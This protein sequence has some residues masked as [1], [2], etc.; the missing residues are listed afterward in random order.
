MPELHILPTTDEAVQAMA[1]FVVDLARER[2]AAQGR[3]T[4]A[5]SGGSTPRLLY[6][7]LA[8]Q[9]HGPELEWDRWHVFWRDERCVPVG[10]E[11]SNYRMAKNALLDHVNIPERQVHRMRGEDVPR[12]AATDY[13]A[14][15][16][17]V[18]Q[19]ESPSFD[20]VL[21]GMGD[22]GHTASLFPGTQ[23]LGE[24]DRLV[25]DNWAPSL[26]VHR[27]TFTLPL[28]NAAKAVAFLEIDET[29]AEML[30]PVLEPAP[31][32]A[33]SP[34]GFVHPSPGVV[35]WFLTTAAAVRLRE[36]EF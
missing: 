36:T 28:I 3:F 24:Q 12:A 26:Q 32:E 10:H 27:L 14:T 7:A 11:D 1:R 33:V 22:D 2:V 23:A 6:Q 17:E 35:H 9:P 30:R 4:I 34:A 21:L 8:S 31:D 18:L 29:K 16:R 13:E 15:I 19:S 20:L 5:L 25:V